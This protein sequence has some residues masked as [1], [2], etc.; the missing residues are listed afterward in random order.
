VRFEPLPSDA[1]VFRAYTGMNNAAPKDV[2]TYKFLNR[3]GTGIEFSRIIQYDRPVLKILHDWWNWREGE[4]RIRSASMQRLGYDRELIWIYVIDLFF[5]N[6][7]VKGLRTLININHRDSTAQFSVQ[8]A[9]RSGLPCIVQQFGCWTVMIPG[10]MPANFAFEESGTARGETYNVRAAERFIR[11]FAADD[12]DKSDDAAASD[13]HSHHEHEH[14]HEATQD[15]SQSAGLIGAHSSESH[16][17]RK[18][19]EGHIVFTEEGDESDSGGGEDKIVD[20]RATIAKQRA[21]DAEETQRL[22]RQFVYNPKLPSDPND[23]FWDRGG[24]RWQEDED[25]FYLAGL[26]AALATG[27]RAPRQKEDDDGDDDEDVDDKKPGVA[28]VTDAPDNDD[29]DAG[30]SESLFGDNDD[31]LADV[32]AEAAAAAEAAGVPGEDEE[33]FGGPLPEMVPPAPID[34]LAGLPELE[35]VNAADILLPPEIGNAPLDKKQQLEA[36]RAMQAQDDEDGVE[37]Y[38]RRMQVRGE[39]L[40]EAVPDETKIRCYD[41]QTYLEAFLLFGTALCHLNKGQMHGAD[42]NDFFYKVCGWKR[43]GEEESDDEG[44]FDDKREETLK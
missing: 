6:L 18:L 36:L 10:E 34:E 14:E 37:D 20:F 23:K 28:I 27:W 29:D 38:I 32:H 13:D 26:R 11:K 4:T 7:D 41:C 39:K 33:G 15:A 8:K 1:T 31:M 43:Q 12:I 16:A 19:R 42:Y 9:R 17:R 30:D 24:T 40:P 25:A 21:P 2:L 5:A 3:S 44:L 35:D 22:A